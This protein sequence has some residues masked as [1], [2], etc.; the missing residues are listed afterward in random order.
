LI[1]FQGSLDVDHYEDL[2]ADAIDR[3]LSRDL[4]DEAYAQALAD[5]AEL[6][7][8]ACTDD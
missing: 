7:A 4:P 1:N 5:E 8:C 2:I 3:V 6:L